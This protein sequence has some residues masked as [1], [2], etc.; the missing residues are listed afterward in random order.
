MKYPTRCLLLAAALMA[1]LP[2]LAQY[3]WIDNA[4]RRVYSDQP[5]PA[6]IPQKNILSERSMPV[7][8]LVP[9]APGSAA[10]GQDQA[11]EDKKK[12]AD[13]AVAAKKKADEQKLAAQR[14]DNCQRARTALAGLQSGARVAQFNAQ[15]ERSYMT[16]DQRAAAIERTQDIIRSDCH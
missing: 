15:G 7:N 1:S 11:L 14:A 4:G 6:N 5:P 8:A 3:S 10:S 2:A 9:A 16:D 12:A 13:A